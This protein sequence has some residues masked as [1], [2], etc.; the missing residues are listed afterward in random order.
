LISQ[1][2]RLLLEKAEAEKIIDDI[3]G[4]HKDG[5][6]SIALIESV[7]QVIEFDRKRSSG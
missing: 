3:F 6:S 5:E 2:A 4:Y 1:H 7:A